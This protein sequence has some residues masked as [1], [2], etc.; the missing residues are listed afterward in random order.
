MDGTQVQGQVFAISLDYDFDGDLV[1]PNEMDDDFQLIPSFFAAH[2]FDD[3]PVAIGFGMYA[4]FAL[5]SD[6]ESDAGFTAPFPGSPLDPGTASQAG[7][8]SLPYKADLKYIKYHAV[9][10]WQVTESLSIAGGVS[11]DHTEVDL[12]SNALDYEGDDTVFGYSLSLL[13]QPNKKHSFG[14]N[15]KTKTEVEYDGKAD[16]FT[17]IIQNQTPVFVPVTLNS[18]ADLIF[19]ESVIFGYSYRPNKNWNFEFN[20]DWTNWDRVNELT[21]ND[22]PGASY[23]LNWESAFIWELGATRYLDDGWHLSAGYTFVENAVP[24][25][26]LLPI[27][28]DSDRHFLA[29]GIGQTLDH[30][31]WVLAYQQAFDDG[32]SVTG[33]GQS[34]T[35]NG[36]FDLDSQAVTFSLN[37]KF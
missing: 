29:V 13:W 12:K 10:A 14:L 5:G 31:S 15:Y 30:V 36:E 1:G 26:E 11:F 16:T 24:D 2:N 23:Q 25:A 35:L 32:R 9:A 34:P 4:P 18:K 37:V 28:P 6:W 22:V 20:I 27:V 33:S 8:A 7:L 3:I 17:T 21:L 19:P